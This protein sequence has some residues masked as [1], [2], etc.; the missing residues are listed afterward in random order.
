LV[1]NVFSPPVVFTNNL[2][3]GSV[4]RAY[5]I[6]LSE[7]ETSV[8]AKIVTSKLPLLTSRKM[9]SSHSGVYSYSYHRLRG[10]SNKSSED[11]KFKEK[12]GR[13]KQTFVTICRVEVNPNKK[14]NKEDDKAEKTNHLDFL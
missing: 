9:C 11:D 1:F 6:T 5:Q 14:A 12:A 2:S 4:C 3:I 7:K 13:R 10:S 8:G